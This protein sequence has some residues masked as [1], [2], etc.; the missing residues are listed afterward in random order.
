MIDGVGGGSRLCG[1]GE[2]AGNPAAVPFSP[3]PARFQLEVREDAGS[4]ET[5]D[6]G[7]T[8]GGAARSPGVGARRGSG[9]AGVLG[10][11]ARRGA[12]CWC[13]RQPRLQTRALPLV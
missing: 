3:G 6:C 2:V 5:R 1:S 7:S 10:V 8:G 13:G 11:G 12:W 4:R 9:S